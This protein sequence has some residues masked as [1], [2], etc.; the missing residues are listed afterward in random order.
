M[1]GEPTFPPLFNGKRVEADDDP[2][3][4]ACRAAA[5]GEAGAGDVFWSAS[6][7]RLSLALVVEPEVPAARA[8]EHEI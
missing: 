6:E 5:D 4:F 7:A 8:L 2:V 3:P 1:T